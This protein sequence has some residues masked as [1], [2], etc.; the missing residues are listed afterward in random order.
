M[1]L[2]EWI[3][4]AFGKIRV[5][6]L[7][8]VATTKWNMHSMKVEIKYPTGTKTDMRETDDN[9]VGTRLL[10]FIYLFIFAC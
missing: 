8:E 3:S 10:L 1:L 4:N 7:M 5:F 2:N 9:P 6:E